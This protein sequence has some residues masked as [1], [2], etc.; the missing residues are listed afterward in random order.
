MMAAAITALWL[1]VF[2][3]ALPGMVT[4]SPPPA[5][6]NALVGGQFTYKAQRG[7]SLTSVG[8]RFGMEVPVLAALN[9]LK[10]TA[11]LKLGQVLRIDNA[12]IALQA[13]D[14]GIVIN[15]PQ[16]MLFYFRS[17]KLVAGYPVGLGRK[18]WPTPRG[19]FDVIEKEKNKTWIVPDSIQEEMLAQGKPLQKQVPPGPDNPLGHYWIRISSSCG[20]HGTNAPAS[21]YHF[22]THGCIRLLPENIAILFEK[23]PLG[24][25][26]KIV[27]QPVLLARLPNGRLYLE[28]HRDVYKK[29]G[30]PLATVKHMAAAAGVESMVDW[31]KV[32]RVIQER[33]GLAEEVSLPARSILK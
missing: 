8:A 3:Q 16:R 32:T 15:V 9:G 13:L 22:Q 30:D 6:S 27:Y 23:V 4:S 1:G 31:Q 21:I 28:I 2:L 12:H 11:W 7:D 29:A 24:T 25:P 18:T 19:N 33:C 26:V 14:D 20:I 10:P 17:G 5:V